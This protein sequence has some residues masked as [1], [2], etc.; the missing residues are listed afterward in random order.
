MTSHVND[1]DHYDK[2]IKSMMYV[3][4]LIVNMFI[5]AAFD[6]STWRIQQLCEIT[7]YW[8]KGG[9]LTRVQSI[10]T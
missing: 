4:T 7:T 5:S 3:S 6:I 9:A 1:L 2:N 8:C 10:L